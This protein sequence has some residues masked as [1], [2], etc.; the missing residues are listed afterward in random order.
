MAL[1]TVFCSWH[2]I[3]SEY[4]VK[5]YFVLELIVW[6]KGWVSVRFLLLDVVL[7][8]SPGYNINLQQRFPDCWI[9]GFYCC[10]FPIGVPLD[11]QSWW[12]CCCLLS[13]GGEMTAIIYNGKCNY[14]PD[15]RKEHSCQNKVQLHWSFISLNSIVNMF[16]LQVL[17][18]TIGSSLWHIVSLTRGMK[19]GRANCDYWD[20]IWVP[21]KM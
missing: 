7:L 12:Q 2:L 14:R 9:K 5:T 20:S 6:L 13:L 11:C 1:T 16:L 4:S 17:K 8:W 3:Y 15:R 21:Q 18:I 10:N 19:N